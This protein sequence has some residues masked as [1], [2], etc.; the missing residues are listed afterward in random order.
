MQ[1][2]LRD[3]ERER[4]REREKRILFCGL[5]VVFESFFTCPLPI[6]CIFVCN[7]EREVGGTGVQKRKPIRVT[8]RLPNDRRLVEMWMRRRQMLRKRKKETVKG[9]RRRDREKRDREG[10]VETDWR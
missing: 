2:Y 1:V 6:L 8:E 4:E 7:S 3:G 9:Q 5:T 10:E